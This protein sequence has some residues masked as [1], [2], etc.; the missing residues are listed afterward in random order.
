MKFNDLAKLV[1]EAKIGKDPMRFVAT[2]PM[3]FRKDTGVANPEIRKQ[4]VNP[5]PD[6]GRYIP[7]DNN[8]LI[9]V[10]LIVTAAD[11]E[12]GKELARV[13]SNYRR[14]H[15]EY[16]AEANHVKRLEEIL[17]KMKSGD[18]TM[19]SKFGNAPEESAYRKKDRRINILKMAK[20]LSR[21]G[22]HFAKQIEE[23]LKHHENLAGENKHKMEQ[24]RP[25]FINAIHDL[26]KEGSINFAKRI[27]Q[28]GRGEFKS[29]EDLDVAGQGPE[30][31]AAVAFL[32]DIFRGKTEFEPLSK[33]VMFDEKQGS[34]P[35]Y[36]IC[37]IYNN[38]INTVAKNDLAGSPERTFNF[39]VGKTQ[40]SMS[41]KRGSTVLKQ[42]QSPELIKVIKL[43]RARKFED[44]KHAVNDSKLD[45]EQRKNLMMDIEGL[46]NGT[47]TEAEVIK[48]L[49]NM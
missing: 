11:P 30:E 41:L 23:E 3:G 28:E 31:R 22:Y 33:L 27:E 25:E 5:T 34:D 49:Y 32:K 7:I 46:K 26:V 44:A 39:V 12:A 10:A 20:P 6:K 21:Q 4:E 2:G 13:M 1:T 24:A 45:V 35:A 43:I 47:K 8:N 36:H 42:K 48:P 9:R 18:T 14:L 17:R 16:T 40:K 15:N 37:N 38:V 19:G 29:L